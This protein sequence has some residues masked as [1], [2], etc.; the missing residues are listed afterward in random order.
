MLT[1]PDFNKESIPLR[2]LTAQETNE[3]IFLKTA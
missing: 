3:N 1:Y 2:S